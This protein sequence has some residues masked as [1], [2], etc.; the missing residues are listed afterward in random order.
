MKCN[1]YI[2]QKVVC[3][4]NKGNFSSRAPAYDRGNNV[5]SLPYLK[6]GHIY[7]IKDIFYDSGCLSDGIVVLVEEIRRNQYDLLGRELGFHHSRFKPLQTKS[8]NSGIEMLRKICVDVSDNV[9][10]KV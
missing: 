1:F 6:V 4:N 3:V 7:T 8:T 10:E 2:G 9:L 5:I